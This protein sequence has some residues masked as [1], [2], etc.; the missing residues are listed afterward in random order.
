MPGSA[1]G[2]AHLFVEFET[3][4]KNGASSARR[5]CVALTPP[6]AS[7]LATM[8]GAFERTDGA[9]WYLAIR[10]NSKNGQTPKWNGVLTLRDPVTA[11]SRSEIWRVR[12][13]DRFPDAAPRGIR[14]SRARVHYCHTDRGRRKRYWETAG[15]VLLT[16][17]V[18][19]VDAAFIYGMVFL[20]GGDGAKRFPAMRRLGRLWRL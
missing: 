7:K 9:S 14:V 11:W 17:V 18:V 4:K 3:A 20:D 1:R 16:P 6:K 19:A 10:S 2:P 5:V 15:K 13:L 8:T 12:E